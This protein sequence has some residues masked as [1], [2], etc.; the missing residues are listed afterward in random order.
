MNEK[1]D[2][3]TYFPFT[4]FRLP[5]CPY[6]TLTTFFLSYQSSTR[7]SWATREGGRRTDGCSRKTGWPAQFFHPELREVLDAIEK[8]ETQMESEPM[9]PAT[10]LK[11]SFHPPR[12][13]P[14]DLQF[15]HAHA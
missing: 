11:S 4:T 7:T 6:E 3:G 2:E 15:P 9:S 13:S 8:D 12:R 5:D 1:R 10:K 14:R